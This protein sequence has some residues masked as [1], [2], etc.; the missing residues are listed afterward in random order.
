MGIVPFIGPVAAAMKVGGVPTPGHR[1]W[2]V[3]CGLSS[4][5]VTSLRYFGASTSW[6]TP[7]QQATDGSKVALDPSTSFSGTPGNMLTDDSLYTQWTHGGV[8][9][10]IYYDFTT[11]I[12]LEALGLRSRSNSSRPSTFQVVYS[13]D[14]STWVDIGADTPFTLDHDTAQYVDLR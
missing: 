5:S 12:L 4:G 10:V 1:Y 9:R 11:P 14:A 13:D 6:A 7:N 3:R 2:G 8:S